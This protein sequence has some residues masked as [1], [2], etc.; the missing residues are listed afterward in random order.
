MKIKDVILYL[1]SLA[2]LPLQESYDNAGL[3]IG[4]FNS[5]V[6]GVTLCLDST[7][8]VVDEAIHKKANLIIAHHPIIF[9]GLKSIT[10]KNYVERVILKAIKNDIAIYAIHTNL[11]NI[12]L[13]VNYK[14]M[15]K[16]NVDSTK[17]LKPISGNLLKLCTYVPVKNADKLRNALFEAGAG[18]IGN[19]SEAS[20]NFLGK[21]T[22]KGNSESSPTIG[23]KNER[24]EIEEYKI[25]VILN[26]YQSEKILKALHNSHP[27][28]EVAYDLVRLENK[29]QTIGA[30][31]I[32]NLDTPINTLDFLKI[33]KSIFNCKVIKH[34]KLITNR[35]QR[36]AV[37]GG[38]GSFLL[39]DAIKQKAD[40]FITSDF[41]YHDFFD[42]D[43]HIIIVDIGHFESEQFTMELLLEN[44]SKK[45]S[46]FATYLTEVNTNP[47]HYYI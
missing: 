40:I 30:G 25:E 31:M 12:Q 34:T 21:G 46:N 3:I 36:V 17:I 29:N 4:D 14:I 18:N 38:S 27:Y 43:N 5:P 6:S 26:D 42:A 44:L 35:I 45:F 23:T 32:G 19:Y 22:F 7:E 47:V 28:E 16:L 8:E 39:K 10:G 11:D 1:E 33:V 20:F 41:K 13:G 9:K 15:E 2:P 37:C 24:T